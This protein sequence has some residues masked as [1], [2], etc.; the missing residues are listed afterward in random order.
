MGAAADQS[1]WGS[2]KRDR[3]HVPRP[4]PHSEETLRWIRNALSQDGRVLRDTACRGEKCDGFGC[5]RLEWD[6]DCNQGSVTY[7]QI[8][9]RMSPL[10]VAKMPPEGLGATEITVSKY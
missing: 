10:P 6:E 5:L 7:L 4:T 3:V 8:L 2:N 9:A 1:R